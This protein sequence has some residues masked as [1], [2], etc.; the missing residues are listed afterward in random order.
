MTEDEKMIPTA[1]SFHKYG[2]NGTQPANRYV[3]TDMAIF[4]PSPT[5]ESISYAAMT[6]RSAITA[7]KTTVIRN[8]PPIP[9]A[10]S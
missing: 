7:G 2:T 10:N 8:S 1:L 6:E 4:F 9:V 3:V 5:H